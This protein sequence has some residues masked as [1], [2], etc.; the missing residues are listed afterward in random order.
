MP[1]P[2]DPSADLLA[3]ALANRAADP[4]GVVPAL[5]A[6]ASAAADA[7]YVSP[8]AGDADEFAD[9]G[10][11]VRAVRK[12]IFAFGYLP[13]DDHGAELDPPL[14][15]AIAAFQAE[16]GITIDGWVGHETWTALED[17]YAFEEETEIARWV[18]APERATV[19]ARAAQR[20][21]VAL[22]LL[23]LEPH[24]ALL[25][26]DQLAGAIATFADLA[27]SLGLAGAELPR[28]YGPDT[29]AALFDHDGFVR[30]LA[31]LDP[32]QG[33][34]PAAQ[35]FIV[36]L[37]CIELWLL[38]YGVDPDDGADDTPQFPAALARFA[39]DLAGQPGA[40]GAG[41][42]PA[43]FAG[44]F[45]GFFRETAALAHHGGI[46]TPADAQ[47]LATELAGRPEAYQSTWFDRIKSI[48]GQIW[49]GLKRVWG[50]FKRLFAA[51]ADKVR[52]V[53][54]L[55]YRLG[56]DVFALGRASLAALPAAI[57]YGFS[58]AMP[59]PAGIALRHDG[60]FDFQLAIRGDA[61]EADVARAAGELRARS[62][63]FV[64]ALRVLRVV[65]AGMALVAAAGSAVFTGPLGAIRLVAGLVGAR[66]DL[67][68]ALDYWHVH[69]D[70][71]ASLS[72]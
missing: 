22:G 15:A 41:F 56:S 51:A 21:L 43:D 70:E 8:H 12:M 55:A 48:G 24:A 7:G 20:R 33:A 4:F 13:E 19:L 28:A 2:D 44:T 64:F 45:P 35:R 17:L 40:A 68:D 46:V 57:R 62:S 25:P 16:A 26:P 65:I 10:D 69:R 59:A 37:A 61:H 14:H 30:R 60:D 52:N 42:D 50:W 54:R 9:A 32:A 27:N 23:E 63:Q 58:G 49:D 31:A 66:G 6:A 39:A 29:L 53:V 1:P 18:R 36:R 38:H 5:A 47:A 72:G 3:T 71:L 34:D 11:R 67:Q